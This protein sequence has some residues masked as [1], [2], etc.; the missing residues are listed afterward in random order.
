MSFSKMH[1]IIFFEFRLCSSNF[2]RIP[3]T[4]NVFPGWLAGL[5]EFIFHHIQ[6]KLSFTLIVVFHVVIM[7]AF[8][9]FLFFCH[10]Y[11]HVG[12]LRCK[13]AFVVCH[14]FL[15]LRKRYHHMVRRPS[16][17]SMPLFLDNS[18]CCCCQSVK[19]ATHPNEVGLF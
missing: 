5:S 2:F 18:H 13:P 4:T 10:F 14:T 19:Q 3:T 16:P 1:D 11:S 7:A 17:F 12:K 8:L 15:L 6:I 9:L